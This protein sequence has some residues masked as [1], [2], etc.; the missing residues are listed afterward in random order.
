MDGHLGAPISAKSKKR[1]AVILVVAGGILCGGLVIAFSKG[2]TRPPTIVADEDPRLTF[3]TPYQNVR[4]EV[5]Y[6][7]DQVCADCHPTQFESFSKTPMGRSLVPISRLAGQERYDAKTM[8]PFEKKGFSFEVIQRAGKVYHRQTRK[9]AQGQVVTEH[10]DEVQYALGSGTRGRSYLINREGYLFQSPISWFSQGETWDLSPGFGEGVV[11]GRPVRVGCLVCHC[12]QA[13]EIKDTENH[14]Q[15]PIFAGYAIGCERCHGPGELHVHA[16]KTGDVEEKDLAHTIV[17]PSRLDPPLREAVCQQC[18]LLGASRVLRRGR[19]MFDYRPGLPLHLFFST[20]VPDPAVTDAES[21]I[22]HVEQMYQSRCF[23]ASN[24]KLGCI[25]CHDP[26][27]VPTEEKKAAYFRGRCLQ[28]H[29]E[30]DCHFPLAARKEKSKE[31]SCIQCHMP[32]APVP[33]VAHTANTDHRIL[34]KPAKTRED[35]PGANTTQPAVP[36]D[37]LL[38]NF[39]QD[40]LEPSD[41]G[42]ERDLGLALVLFSSSHSSHLRT[43]LGQA[44]PRLQKA[45]RDHPDDANALE[46]LATTLWQRGSQREARATIEQALA[47]APER[48]STLYRAALYA[49]S[50]GRKEAAIDYCRRLV[51]IN[52]WEPKYRIQLADLLTD[53]GQWSEAIPECQAVLQVEP[54]NAEIRLLLMQCYV[55]TGKR[56]QAENE[57]EIMLKLKPEKKASLREWFNQAVR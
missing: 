27:S 49:E 36:P 15:T 2:R 16:E 8:N 29:R 1:L 53:K 42:A 4:P 50:W 45:V 31:D 18:H 23:R 11:S 39:Q 30:V 40:L 51:K 38:V 28:C 35:A 32:R 5:K 48:E 22:G 54:S 43:A 37:P 34:A 3:P 46:A 19:Q 14:Y 44:L 9:D 25:S 6:V 55:H 7:G 52:P 56:D 17:N 41:A 13:R 21:D 47:L 10:E 33:G 26:H 57:L 12:N 20:F 24:G